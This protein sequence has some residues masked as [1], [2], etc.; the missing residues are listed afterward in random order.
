M[1]FLRSEEILG[2]ARKCQFRLVYRNK[3]IMYAEFEALG[4]LT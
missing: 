3:G 2:H 4:K 1:Y